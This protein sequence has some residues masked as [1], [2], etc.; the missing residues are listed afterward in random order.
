MAAA[1]LQQL[2]DALSPPPPPNNTKNTNHQTS[3]MA[4]KLN[5]NGIPSFDDLPLREGDPPH[6]A[7]GLYGDHDELGTLN[8]LT[9]ARVAAAAKSE[10]QKGIRY[11]LSLWSSCRVIAMIVAVVGVVGSRFR[12]TARPFFFK[13]SAT[14]SMSQEIYLYIYM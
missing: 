13:L 6:S 7:W 9:D 2:G 5:E 11:V 12:N 1:R 10:I 14:K 3:K 4:P 8:R